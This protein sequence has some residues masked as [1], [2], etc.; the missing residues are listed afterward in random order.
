MKVSLDSGSK[1]GFNKTTKF[2]NAMIRQNIFDA[3]SSYGQLGVA[4]LEAATPRETGKT[5]ASWGFVVENNRRTATIS[6]TNSSLDD[7]GV[8]I[9]IMLQYGHGT[10]TGGYV[11]GEDYINPAT[12]GV[13]DKIRDDVWKVVQTA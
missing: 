2:L 7:E 3:L 10:G 1:N 5:A 9:A 12:K 11:A 6:W 4:A 13:F 8:P